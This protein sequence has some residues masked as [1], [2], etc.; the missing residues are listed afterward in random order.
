VFRTTMGMEAGRTGAMVLEKSTVAPN[1]AISAA[2][3]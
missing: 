2:S 3:S 1:L